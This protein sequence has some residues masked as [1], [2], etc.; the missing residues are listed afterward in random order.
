MSV[1]RILDVTSDL[2]ADGRATIDCNGW[3]YAEVQLVSPST[4]VNFETT[5]DSGAVTGV[6]DG[7]A[8]SAQNFVS[9][10]GVNVTS[11]SS[12]TSLNAS[13]IVKFTNLGQYLRLIGVGV[14]ATGAF[15][16]LYKIR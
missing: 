12:V 7:S 2:N 16:R 3:D 10:Q 14:T 13:G 4:T 5:I 1:P 9:V 15:I 6:S 11:G 8:A